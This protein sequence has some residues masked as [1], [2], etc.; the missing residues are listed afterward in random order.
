MVTVERVADLVATTS[1]PDHKRLERHAQVVDDQFVA[2]RMSAHHAGVSMPQSVYSHR[3]VRLPE[4]VQPASPV[5]PPY[6]LAIRRAFV[7][8]G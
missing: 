4:G 8:P 5:G 2:R 3:E 6:R 7:A 1:Y